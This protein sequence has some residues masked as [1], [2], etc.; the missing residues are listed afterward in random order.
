MLAREQRLTPDG[1][2]EDNNGR[3]VGAHDALVSSSESESAKRMKRAN[4]IQR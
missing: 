2:T 4:N 3:R 1:E